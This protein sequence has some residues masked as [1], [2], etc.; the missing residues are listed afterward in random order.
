MSIYFIQGVHAPTLT[1]EFYTAKSKFAKMF[2]LGERKYEDFVSK[3]SFLAEHPSINEQ[4]L[5][6]AV[7]SAIL[8]RNDLA[9]DIPNPLEVSQQMIFFIL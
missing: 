4:I 9:N 5:Q 2:L 7:I 6:S 3:V 8:Q 1:K